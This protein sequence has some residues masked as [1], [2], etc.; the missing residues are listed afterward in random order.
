MTTTGSASPVV[1]PASLH[2]C[3]DA[4]VAALTDLAAVDDRVV[5]VVNDSVGSSNLGGFQQEFP[6][7]LINV[8]IA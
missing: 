1:E 2:D 5:A 3:R 6:D 4:W 8:G 7:R